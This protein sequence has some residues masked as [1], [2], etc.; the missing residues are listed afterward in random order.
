MI[1]AIPPDALEIARNMA[2]SP[3]NWPPMRVKQVAEL[4]NDFVAAT[5]MNEG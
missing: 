3:D 2:Q 1:E 4:L 5:Y